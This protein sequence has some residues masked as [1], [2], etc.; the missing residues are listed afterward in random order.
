MPRRKFLYFVQA[1]DSQGNK[2]KVPVYLQ[3]DAYYIDDKKIPKGT[4][5]ESGIEKILGLEVIGAIPPHSVHDD[6]KFSQ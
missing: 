5:I 4:D 1:K 2:K 6:T 3:D